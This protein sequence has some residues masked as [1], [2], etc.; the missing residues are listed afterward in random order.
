MLE[1]YGERMELSGRKE[2]ISEIQGAVVRMTRVIDKVLLTSRLELQRWD[3][4]SEA[5]DPTA[6]CEEFL[7]QE[8]GQSGQMHRIQ[9]R[10]AD[11]PEKVAMDQ[12]VL[13]IA[14]QNLLSNALKYSAPESQVTLE[15]SSD[16]AGRI[17]FSVRDCGIGIPAA[18]MAGIFTSFYRASNVGD[19]PGT[20]L[21]LAI[22]KAC[23]DIHGGTVE[24]QSNPGTG[25]YIRMCFPDWLRLPS[26]PQEVGASSA[27]VTT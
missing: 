7:M 27:K 14:L 5:F 6:W 15:L 24:I 22:V 26:A 10:F 4:K 12:R 3:L 23:A 2:R 13:E 21:G 16:A 1:R 17:L 20:G 9:V 19:V 25:T 11:L 8:F 18:D